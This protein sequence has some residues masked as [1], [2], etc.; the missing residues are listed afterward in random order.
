MVSLAGGSTFQMD[1][2]TC[3]GPEA[4][5]GMQTG[6]WAGCA[7]ASCIQSPSRPKTKEAEEPACLCDGH[8]PVHVSWCKWCS[9][10]AFP[11]GPQ[12][13]RKAA[14]WPG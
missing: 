12:G 8:V 6:E 14:P 10:F 4:S 2:S 11:G 5:L 3:K 7:M 13:P 9:A 1:N